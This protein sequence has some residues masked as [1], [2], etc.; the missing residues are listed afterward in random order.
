MHAYTYDS[1]VV[2]NIARVC[3]HVSGENARY[4]FLCAYIGCIDACCCSMYALFL[5]Y[6]CI[7]SND[8]VY[9]CVFLINVFTFLIQATAASGVCM[10]V[11]Y[12]CMILAYGCVCL[13]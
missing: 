2:M 9:A 11:V 4:L 10:L 5:V 6:T 8:Q 3:M 13:K 12:L 1:V 7:L